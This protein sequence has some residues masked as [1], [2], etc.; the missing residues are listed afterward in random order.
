VT[1]I[2]LAKRGA[3]GQ[4]FSRATKVRKTSSFSPGQTSFGGVKARGMLL[5]MLGVALLL[6]ASCKR[7]PGTERSFFPASN[8]VAGWAKTGDIRTFEAADLWKYIDGEAERYLKAGVQR[9]S[10]SDY[11]FQ[12]KVDAVVDIYTMGNAEGA[13][14]VFKSE[15]AVDVKPIQLGD[16]ARLSSQSLV[17]RKG[18]CLVRIVAFEESAETQQA[19]LQLGHGIELRL[20]R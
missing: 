8:Q 5:V 18:A 14:K 7:Q 9:V 4:G 10:T 20:A 2:D 11:K 12:N 3:E 19:L 17:F 6:D 15:S 16:G 13:E 1:S